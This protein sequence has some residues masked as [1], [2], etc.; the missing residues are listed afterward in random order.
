MFAFIG[1]WFLSKFCKLTD[2]QVISVANGLRLLAALTLTF[3]RRVEYIYLGTILNTSA[4]LHASMMR[5][6]LSKIVPS[7]DL[8]M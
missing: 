6:F 3:G 8:G 7:N 1:V 5:V 2:M 4:V